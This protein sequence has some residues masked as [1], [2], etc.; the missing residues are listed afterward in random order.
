MN[1]L[2]TIALYK[3][4][5]NNHM[6]YDHN[7]EQFSKPTNLYAPKLYQVNFVTKEIYKTPFCGFCKPIYP[8]DTP[9]NITCSMCPECNIYVPIKEGFHVSCEFCEACTKNSMTHYYSHY[10]GQCKAC[11]SI[12]DTDR[13]SM[14]PLCL[15]CYKFSTFHKCK[16]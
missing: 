5:D 10:P 8:F 4:I 6:H 1:N 15:R 2:D 9:N 11:T 7:N 14:C 3:C 12:N 13:H 16:V